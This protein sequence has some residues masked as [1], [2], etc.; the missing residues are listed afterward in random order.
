MVRIGAAAVGS[1]FDPRL[2]PKEDVASFRE[3]Q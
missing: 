2:M 3:R 1:G